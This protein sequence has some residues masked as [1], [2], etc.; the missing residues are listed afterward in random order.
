MTDSFVIPRQLYGIIGHPL[1]HTMSPAL[2]NWGFALH[3]IP[4]VY[5]AW[6]LQPGGTGD[7]VQA[8]RTLNIRGASVTIPHKEAVQ[9]FLDRITDRARAVGAVNTLFWRDGELWGENTDVTGF[10]APLLRRYGKVTEGDCG[11]AE[12]GESYPLPRAALV[13][14]AGGAARAVLAGLQELGVATVYL[15]NRTNAKAASMVNAVAH[16]FARLTPDMPPDACPVRYLPWED[17]TSV[18]VDL[19]INT[20][21]LGMAGERVGETPYPAEALAWQRQQR[22]ANAPPPL[23]YDLVY[24]PLHTRLLC[25]AAAAGWD[26]Q[27]GLDMFVEQGREQFRI[28]TGHMLPAPEA[29]QRVAALVGVAL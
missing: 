25:E 11:L 14:G 24:N 29:R 16:E 1:G 26:T 2:H 18:P 3:G 21:P 8:M 12:G 23:A 9:A 27:D 13:L 19:V 28:W 6:P 10:L 7:F 20:T 17:R 5:M 15:C 22:A 4:A